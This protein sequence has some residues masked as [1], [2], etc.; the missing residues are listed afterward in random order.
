MRIITEDEAPSLK[1]LVE[2]IGTGKLYN[3]SQATSI[4][5]KN[6]GTDTPLLCEYIEQSSGGRTVKR[7][8]PLVQRI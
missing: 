8:L 7:Y 6:A 2:V 1:G 5:K 4:A 3:K